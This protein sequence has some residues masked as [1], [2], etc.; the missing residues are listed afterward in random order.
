MTRTYQ[1]V[2]MML[3]VAGVQYA[4]ADRLAREMSR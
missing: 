3:L 2:L 1:S 4:E